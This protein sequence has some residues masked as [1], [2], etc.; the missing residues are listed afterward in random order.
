[1]LL[2]ETFRFLRTRIRKKENNVTNQI[3]RYAAVNTLET[4]SIQKILTYEH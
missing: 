4:E 1:M 3:K 2:N